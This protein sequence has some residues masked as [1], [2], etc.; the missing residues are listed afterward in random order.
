MSLGLSHIWTGLISSIVFMSSSLVLSNSA[1]TGSLSK[2]EFC[3][4]V[5]FR[6]SIG[7]ICLAR[8]LIL[9]T[10]EHL[11]LALITGN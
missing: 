1:S 11:S 9:V 3:E 7:S 4:F 5:A 2:V 6:S 10:V 8:V